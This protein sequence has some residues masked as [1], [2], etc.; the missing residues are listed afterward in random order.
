MKT[1]VA[2]TG[3]LAGLVTVL[4]LWRMVVERHLAAEPSYWLITLLTA[5]L[6]GWAFRLL[7]GARA[8]TSDH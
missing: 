7:R 5:G 2:T 1:Y 4:H 6:A 8:L 3:G